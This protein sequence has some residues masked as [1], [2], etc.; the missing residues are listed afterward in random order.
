MKLDNKFYIIGLNQVILYIE[1][2]SIN[3]SC[4]SFF[5]GKNYN[6]QFIFYQMQNF[7]LYKLSNL[8]SVKLNKFSKN[9]YSNK[10]NRLFSKNINQSDIMIWTI[11][12]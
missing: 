1:E 11:I 10:E 2:S 9:I 4:I 7:I 12:I 8:N 6:I 5:L 3:I